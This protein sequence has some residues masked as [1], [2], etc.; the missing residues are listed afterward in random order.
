MNEFN[1]IFKALFN[2]KW[3][4]Q[5]DQHQNSWLHTLKPSV[6]TKPIFYQGK[7][8]HTKIITRLR[9]G[10]TNLAGQ[11]GQFSRKTSPLCQQC[12]V[13]EDIS[14][15]LLA[16]NKHEQARKKLK[17]ALAINNINQLNIKTLLA[18]PK[19]LLNYVYHHLINF[20]SDIDYLDII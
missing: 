15:V 17:T 4:A 1:A 13:K 2:Q 7:R 19:T 11:V 3:Q 20:I 10:T 14:H 12:G 6:N 9:L 5:W 16:C 8:F 18:P